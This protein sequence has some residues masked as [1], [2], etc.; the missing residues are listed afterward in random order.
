MATEIQG[1]VILKLKRQTGTSKAGNAWQKDEY[2]LEQ[3][4]QF[5]RKV[6]VTVFGKNCDT[7]S[8]EVGKEYI[9]S[10]DVESRE[11]NERWYTDV[12]VYACRP[13]GAAET[14]YNNAPADG[15][16]APEA[17]AAPANPFGAPEADSNDDLPF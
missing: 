8:M 11:Y 17:P 3:P 7:I 1:T 2:V 16:G 12:N 9:L 15:F 6:K 14:S 10:V 5:P 4:G 13:V